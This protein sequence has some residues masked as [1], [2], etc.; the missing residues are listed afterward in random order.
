MKEEKG[1]VGKGGKEGWKKREK[2]LRERKR[3]GG[4]GRGVEREEDWKKKRSIQPGNSYSIL[5]PGQAI[6]GQR[7]ED[8]IPGCEGPCWELRQISSD[9]KEYSQ[10]K[11]VNLKRI[12]YQTSPLV[13][14]F[15]VRLGTSPRLFVVHFLLTDC[16]RPLLVSVSLSDPPIPS[17]PVLVLIPH[18]PPVHITDQRGHL[19]LPLTWWT[20]DVGLMTRMLCDLLIIGQITK[21]K[22]LHLHIFPSPLSFS[23]FPCLDFIYIYNLKKKS[24]YL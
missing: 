3:A 8:K 7:S 1:R 15:S 13:W 2:R 20:H 11:T 4:A 19:S 12:C 14:V 5:T 16:L 18:L 24:H 6:L 10:V 23:I 9:T 21:D 17:L 22:M